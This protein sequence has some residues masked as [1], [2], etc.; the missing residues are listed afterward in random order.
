MP[1]LRLTAEERERK[2]IEESFAASQARVDRYWN[3][4]PQEPEQPNGH[5]IAAKLDWPEPRP[6]PNGL[7]KVDAFAYEF[8]PDRLAPWALDVSNRLQ[9]PPDYV[10]VAVITALGSVIG[11]RAGIKPQAKT[12]WTEIP[13]LWGMFIGRPGMLKS[14]AMTEALK[15]IHHLEAEAAKENEIA[16]QAYAAGLDTYD[17][18]KKVRVSLEKEALKK[19]KDGAKVEINFDLG[20]EPKEPLPVRYR[21]SNST[22]EAIGVLLAANPSG[23]LVER[24]ELVS[25]LRHLDRDEQTVARSFYLSG[26]SGQQS[27]TFDRLRALN[28]K[29]M[30][31]PATVKTFKTSFEGFEGDPGRGILKN[32][33]ERVCAQ[34]GGGARTNPPTDAPTI[35]IQGA[36]VW[37]H[38]ECSRF[39]ICDHC[40][41]GDPDEAT[42]TAAVTGE[43]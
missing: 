39:W 30:P 3:D 2:R 13:N 28:F 43:N 9:C 29:N 27:Y 21:T 5:P 36:G 16:A 19:S 22:Y 17:L 14:P 31:T 32:H 18:R 40:H 35:P 11:R 10:G 23:I 38:P 37:L 15:H 41:E 12:D 34:C 4:Q 33:D 42:K 24:D 6:L 7:P 1:R 8:L 26:W 20:E 25:L